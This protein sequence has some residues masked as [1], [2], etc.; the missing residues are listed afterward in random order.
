MERNIESE[1]KEKYTKL[2]DESKEEFKEDI[3]EMLTDK[4]EED[5]EMNIDSTDD[6]VRVERMLQESME[7]SKEAEEVQELAEA[8]NLSDVK[9][10]TF[11]AKANRYLTDLSGNT[12]ISSGLQNDINLQAG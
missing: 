2:N 3:H 10:K 11:K 1:I 6:Y 9:L 7:I 4:L 12:I 8:G 5:K